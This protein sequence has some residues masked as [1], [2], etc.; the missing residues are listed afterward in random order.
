MLESESKSEMML[1]SV[2]WL[3]FISLL[4]GNKECRRLLDHR[5]WVRQRWAR[6][7]DLTTRIIITMITIT[8]IM[9]AMIMIAMITIVMIMI[10][11]ITMIM[12]TIVK[13]SGCRN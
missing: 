4:E 12:I 11:M 2:H 1:K 8:M 6:N 10:A 9:I 13:G 5:C 3:G 7:P